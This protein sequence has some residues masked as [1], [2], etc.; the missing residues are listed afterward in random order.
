[1]VDE[2]TS[3]YSEILEETWNGSTLN[4]PPLAGGQKAPQEG[5]NTLSAA[6][7]K[8]GIEHG[9]LYNQSQSS[10]QNPYE[11]EEGQSIDKQRLF[12]MIDYILQDL[13]NSKITDRTA[14]MAL[15]K[16]KNWVK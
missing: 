4:R 1:M 8:I 12:D 5:K 15:G 11:Q 6:G 13:D 16:L 2:L 9:S 3:L 10:G 7:S 14:I